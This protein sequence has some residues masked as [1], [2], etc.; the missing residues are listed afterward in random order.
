MPLP[1]I[2]AARAAEPSFSCTGPVTPA[3]AAICKD[4]DL[5]ALDRTLA[6]AF[7]S[8][9]DAIAAGTARADD[10]DRDAVVVTQKA[11]IAHCNECGSDKTCIRKAYGVRIGALTAGP[12]RPIRRAAIP[13]APSRPPSMSNSAC[14]RPP[15]R[16]RP[17]MRRTAAS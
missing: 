10:D 14:R 9:L 13:L 6:A 11:W 2:R 17:A 1:S 16:T 4:D 8:K 7:K 3:E 15:P 12:N 5:A